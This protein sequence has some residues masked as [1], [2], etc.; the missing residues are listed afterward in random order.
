T[1][2]GMAIVYGII[3]K[4]K[5]EMEINSEPNKGTTFTIT[6]PRRA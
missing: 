4:H 2:L 5:G 6:L 3:R 1:G